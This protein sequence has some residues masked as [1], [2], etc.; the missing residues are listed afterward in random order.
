MHSVRETGGVK[1]SV[2]YLQAFLDCRE[3]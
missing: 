3:N 1:E 2:K